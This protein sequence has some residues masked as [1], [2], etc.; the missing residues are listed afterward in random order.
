MPQG[1]G[2]RLVNGHEVRARRLLVL[3]LGHLQVV[4]K[5]LRQHAAHAVRAHVCVCVSP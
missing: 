5:H 2:A 1:G 3:L 4:V